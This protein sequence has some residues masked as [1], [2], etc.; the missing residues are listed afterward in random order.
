M[1]GVHTLTIYL[2]EL[3]AFQSSFSRLSAD[4]FSQLPATDVPVLSDWLGRAHYQKQAAMALPLPAFGLQAEA[5]IPWAALTAQTEPALAGLKPAGGWLR[6]D[7]VCLQPD[8]DSALLVAHE[9][10]AL[11][12]EEAQ[13]LVADINQHFA[14]EPWQLHYAAPHRWYI[15]LQHPQ[16]L[17][18]TPLQHVMGKHV[19]HFLPRGEDA[20]YWQR[21]SNELQML[22]HTAAV[23]VQREQGNRHT[24][25]SVWLWGNGGLP[26]RT[27][28]SQYA[29]VISDDRVFAGIAD[30][31]NLSLLPATTCSFEDATAAPTLLAINN[32]TER[33]QQHDLYGF[34]QT[35]LTLQ[36][37]YFQPAERML[38]QQKIARIILLD[39][40]GHRFSIG[41]K[42]FYHVWRRSKPFYRLPYE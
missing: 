25:N 28:D 31:C 22:L 40:Q 14:N 33:V 4:E 32:L 27:G 38:Q 20:D 18:T 23:N 41:R 26:K 30:Y 12:M 11:S 6:A 15:A 16:Q 3:F 10:L 2:P 7:P 13:I 34:M 29:Q 42:R 19:Q 35:L 1:A 9:A 24:A 21:I 5:D 17:Q 36:Q 37:Q 39:N 8:R